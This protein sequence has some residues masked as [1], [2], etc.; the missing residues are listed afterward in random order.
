MSHLAEHECLGKRSSG[1]KPTAYG[2]WCRFVCLAVIWGVL[3]VR[4]FV[5]DDFFFGF[6]LGLF[7]CVCV[8]FSSFC[9]M[10]SR[11]SC[12]TWCNPLGIY[13]VV[14]LLVFVLVLVWVWF[15][16]SPVF[17]KRFCNCLNEL[18][19]VIIHLM[20]TVEGI[21]GRWLP[22]GLSRNPFGILAIGPK[23]NVSSKNKQKDTKQ[24]YA[25]CK[26]IPIDLSSTP[27]PPPPP[28]ASPFS[29]C[30]F[31]ANLLC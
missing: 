8:C 1:H 20:Y 23:S 3:V 26:I 25:N 18:S 24:N 19:L 17:A 2:C 30:C 7:S 11:R 28:R 9:W 13:L 16:G 5:W 27:P 12:F 10:N 22:P 6:F 31:L 15:W 4:T 21:P 29:L 14:L